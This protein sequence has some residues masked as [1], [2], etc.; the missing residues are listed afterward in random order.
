MKQAKCYSRPGS[1]TSLTR[2]AWCFVTLA[3]AVSA[4]ACDIPVYEYTLHNWTRDP[5]HAYYLYRGTEAAL[6]AQVN[7]YLER[8]ARGPETNLAF[9]MMDLDGPE[10]ATALDQRVREGNQKS[11]LPMHIVLTPRG[12]TLLAQRLDLPTARA[13]ISSPKRKLLADQLCKGKQG[14]L[15]LL[16]GPD[17]VENQTA[18]SV[19]GEAVTA[20]ADN[21]WDVGLIEI[22]RSDP[23]EHWLVQQLLHLEQDLK[24]I[25][26]AMVFSVFGRAHALEPYLGKGITRSNMD[27]LIAFVNGP[28]TCQVKAASFGLDLLTSWN[29]QAVVPTRPE[30]DKPMEPGGFISFG[31]EETPEG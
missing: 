5:F 4:C 7:R 29:W 18:R 15:L 14:V 2:W 17:K 24:D 27:E 31:S 9:T 12:A 23:Q 26:N 20:A 28:C 8:I 3:I 1:P 19:L 16:L 13:L 11:K 6:D 21:Q 10:P 25:P 30:L 22:A